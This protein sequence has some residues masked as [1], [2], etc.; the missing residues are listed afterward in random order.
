ML[1][2]A[3]LLCALLLVSSPNT[4]TQAF[5]ERGG[6][7]AVADD[8]VVSQLRYKRNMLGDLIAAKDVQVRVVVRYC[9]LGIF[10]VCAGAVVMLAAAASFCTRALSC[11]RARLDVQPFLHHQSSACDPSL[12]P[13]FLPSSLHA[14]RTRRTTCRP[15]AWATWRLTAT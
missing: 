14:L 3:V 9:V 10:A 12:S 8:T 7:E 5:A 13:S 1:S 6:G 2:C 11:W 4:H 15:A